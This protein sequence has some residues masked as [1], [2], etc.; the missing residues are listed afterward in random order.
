MAEKKPEDYLKSLNMPEACARCG[1]RQMEDTWPIYSR[2][3]FSF[4]LTRTTYKKSRFHVPIC[5]VCKSEMEKDNAFWQRVGWVSG[6]G[7]FV[8]LALTI[9]IYRFGLFFFI[10]SILSLGVYIFA[11]I[12]RSK[13]WRNSDI[14]SFDGQHFT[15]TNKAFQKQFANQN[16]QLVKKE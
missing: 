9:F 7:I 15:F 2:Y 5:N 13:Y 10:L 11:S 3:N 1:E 12:K 16:P 8:M 4:K 6:V 14:A